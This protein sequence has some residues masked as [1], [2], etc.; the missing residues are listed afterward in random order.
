MPTRSSCW[1]RA[2]S[3]SRSRISRCSRA[4]GSTPNSTAAS[5]SK[6]NSRR[7]DMAELDYH[8]EEALGRAYDAR[9]MRRLLGYLSAYKLKVT[10]AT[11][12]VLAQAGLEIVGPWL[13]KVA[14]DGDI[15]AGNF[16]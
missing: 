3:P 9:L 14:I 5:C 1:T 2:G 16:A 8:E 15:G 10:I 11:I 4:A 6:K 12:L 7:P 13:V